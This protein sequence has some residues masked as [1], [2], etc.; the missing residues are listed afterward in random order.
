MTF[1]QVIQSVNVALRVCF[2]MLMCLGLL[3]ATVFRFMD[4]V[5][6]SDW[7]MVCSILFGADRIGHAIT[8]GMSG[9]SLQRAGRS[10]IQ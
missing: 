5:T 2:F 1:E 3:I 10:E 4:L 6:G 7:V 9:R 8:D